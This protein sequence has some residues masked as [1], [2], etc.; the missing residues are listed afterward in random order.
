MCV[1]VCVCDQI[2]V[3]MHVG[4]TSSRY[5]RCRIDLVPMSIRVVLLSRKLQFSIPHNQMCVT[6]GTWDACYSTK[7]LKVFHS[8]HTRM[9][10]LHVT[11]HFVYQTHAGSGGVKHFNMLVAAAMAIHGPCVY[12]Y[13]VLTGINVP[14]TQLL[15]GI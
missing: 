6:E 14:L 1:C 4:S 9:V 3:T 7:Q 8:I 13:N 2:P 5:R 10:I 11:L 12:T 15:H